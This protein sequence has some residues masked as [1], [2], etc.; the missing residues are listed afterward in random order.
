MQG[1]AIKEFDEFV[2]KLREKNIDVIVVDDTPEP[3]T[4]DSIFPNNWVSFHNDGSIVL[5]PMY[6]VNRRL[7]RKPAVLMEVAKKF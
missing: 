7:E 4:P 2:R 6:A 5:Y 3:H 1:K